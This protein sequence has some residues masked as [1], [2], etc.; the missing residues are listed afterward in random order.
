MCRKEAEI[1][2]QYHLLHFLP[3]SRTTIAAGVKEAR[4]GHL[5]PYPNDTLVCSGLEPGRTYEQ[6][7][8]LCL[9]VASRT[10]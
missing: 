10:S 9:S 6:I 7:H 3:P 2:R 8:F 5:D 4:P 1:C